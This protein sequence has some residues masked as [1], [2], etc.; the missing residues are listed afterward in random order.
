MLIEGPQD[1]Y[2]NT[3]Y[4]IHIHG[5]QL[6]LYNFFQRIGV[7]KRLIKWSPKLP[8]SGYQH[9]EEQEAM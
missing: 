8:V 7:L 4:N 1:D 6:H 2:L 5:Y 3:L 9:Q